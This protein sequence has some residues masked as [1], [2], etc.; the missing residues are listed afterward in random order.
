[1]ATFQLHNRSG[2]EYQ[3]RIDDVSGTVSYVGD[4]QPG[5]A[6]S[7][8]VWRIKKIDTTSGTVITWA[9]GSSAFDKIWNSRTDYDYS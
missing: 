4:A 2:A 6:T 5:V 8:T 3:T 1:M 7:E 9:E